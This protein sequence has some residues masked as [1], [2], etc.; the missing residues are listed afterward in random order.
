MRLL[1]EGYAA[2]HTTMVLF[3]RY[4]TLHSVV[5]K[6]EQ[7][8][9]EH[10]AVFFISYCLDISFNLSLPTLHFYLKDAKKLQ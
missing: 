7:T 10:S 6:V 9:W 3:D 8:G 5:M 4:A 2:W 1:Y